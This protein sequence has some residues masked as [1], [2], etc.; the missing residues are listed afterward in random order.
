MYTGMHSLKEKRERNEMDKRLTQVLLIRW[1]GPLYCDLFKGIE[2]AMYQVAFS[3]VLHLMKG[4]AQKR[5]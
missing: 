1:V 4:V 5:G 3:V 2:C